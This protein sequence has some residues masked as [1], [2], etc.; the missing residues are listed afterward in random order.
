M[1][2]LMFALLTAIHVMA[3]GDQPRRCSSD[4]YGHTTCE[5][6]RGQVRCSRDNYGHE[7]CDGPG[8][9][10]GRLRA[11]APGCGCWPGWAAPDGG[12][13]NTAA[14]RRATIPCG[15]RR[16]A[17]SGKLRSVERETRRA[18]RCGKSCGA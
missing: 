12:A 10:P 6:P 17:G 14:G 9:W 5:T 13:G 8:G 1:V 11:W 18:S 16:G 15:R 2:Q 4:N 3:G 7:T